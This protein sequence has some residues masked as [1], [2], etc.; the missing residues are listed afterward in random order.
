MYGIQHRFLKAM[1]GFACGRHLAITANHNL[2]D[3]LAR[4]EG[5]E[6]ESSHGGVATGMRIRHYP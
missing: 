6:L 2:Q 5:Q 1:T 4:F 3:I